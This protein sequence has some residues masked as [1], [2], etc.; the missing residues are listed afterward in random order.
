MT[1][2]HRQSLIERQTGETNSMYGRKGE[3]NPLYGVPKTEECKK[4]LSD[5]NLRGKSHKAKAVVNTIT[6]QEWECILDA[7]EANRIDAKLLSRYLKNKFFNPTDLIYKN[8]ESRKKDLLTISDSRNIVLDT[9]T[10]VF[11][12]S[13]Q[14]ASETYNIAYSTLVSQLKG[15][16]KNKTNL[17]IV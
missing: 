10:G 12:Y 15:K 17:I 9:Q 11:Y 5:L 8:P 2:E 1:N 3:L 7:A 4:K 14:D 6:N 13:I 16:Y